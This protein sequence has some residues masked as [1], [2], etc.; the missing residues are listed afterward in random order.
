LTC[1]GRS[2]G[3]G[4]GDPA[5]EGVNGCSAR[6]SA[7]QSDMQR[8]NLFILTGAL[9][10]GY[11]TRPDDYRA[12][13][14]S[15]KRIY[16]PLWRWMPIYTSMGNHESLLAIDDAGV[17][18]DRASP[19]SAEELFAAAFVHPLNGPSPEREGAPPYRG[20]V[21]SWEHSD[22]HFVQLDSHY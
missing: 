17:R 19:E 11:T 20:S 2:G 12:Q 8:P 13:L 10:S 3:L 14:R 6:A 9:I 7:A 21:Y 18:I 1:D 22:C 15:W 4:G 16:G 5:L